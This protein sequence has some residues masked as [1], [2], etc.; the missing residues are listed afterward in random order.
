M[1]GRIMLPLIPLDVYIRMPETCDYVRLPGKGEL[2]LQI[3][4]RL[5]PADCK[6][7]RV[8]WILGW[9]EGGQYDHRVLKSGRKN[10]KTQRAGSLRSTLPGVIGSENAARGIG[11]EK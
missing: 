1:A 8:S 5:L 11:A 9:R 7:G 6:I 10:Q 2:R 3:E 4:L